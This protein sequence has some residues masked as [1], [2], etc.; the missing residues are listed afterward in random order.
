MRYLLEVVCTAGNIF[1]VFTSESVRVKDSVVST[2]HQARVALHTDDVATTVLCRIARMRQEPGSW[3]LAV[4]ICWALKANNVLRNAVFHEVRPVAAMDPLIIGQARSAG[5][6]F[7]FTVG[8]QGVIGLTCAIGV[9]AKRILTD[10]I[11]QRNQVS[12]AL[13]TVNSPV[14]V[15]MVVNST[16]AI[17]EQTILADFICQGS[18]GAF[19]EFVATGWV[20]VQLQPIAFWACIE[21][22]RC[23]KSQ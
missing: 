16:L 23:G 19:V 7:G 2:A 18:V 14:V 20:R 12:L 21:L 11:T 9:D 22:L 5:L 8:A 1:W 17:K 6:I 13:S 10:S 15:A 3:I 4:Y